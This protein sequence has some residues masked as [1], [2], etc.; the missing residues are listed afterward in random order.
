MGGG[1]ERREGSNL[2]LAALSSCNEGLRFVQS[3]CIVIS[4][5]CATINLSCI[6]VCFNMLI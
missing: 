1:K 4:C 5:I 2:V 6:D 3:D